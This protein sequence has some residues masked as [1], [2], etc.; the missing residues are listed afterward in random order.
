MCFSDYPAGPHN[1]K[2]SSSIGMGL[3]CRYPCAM[4]HFSELSETLLFL[5]LNP[6]GDNFQIQALRHGDNGGNQRGILTVPGDIPHKSLIDLQHIKR[7]F[8]QIAEG[9][10]TRTKI[11][12]GKA[13][14]GRTEAVQDM[15]CFRI[16]RHNDRVQ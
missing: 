6:F 11:I 4:S 12:D 13:N 5:R 9:R 15:G 8:L 1:F 14:P 3:P 7:I 2:V 16:I 10:I